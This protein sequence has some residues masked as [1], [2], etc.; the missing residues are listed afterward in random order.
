MI[1]DLLEIS[2]DCGIRSA[3]LNS[4][5]NRNAMSLQMMR[6][7]LEL[8]DEH[9]ADP[10]ARALVLGHQG[11]VFCAGIDLIERRT[12]PPDEAV[13]SE[14][15]A[16][17]LTE[18]WA[19]ETPLVCQV[20]G[21]VRGGGMG[22]LSCADFVLAGP[23]ASFAYT[24]IRVGV[25]PALVGALALLGGGGRQ[26]VP[27]LLTGETFNAETAGA[28]GLVTHVL[29]DTDTALVA[30]LNSLTQGGP[31]AQRETKRLV[32]SFSNRDVSIAIAEMTALSAQFFTSEEASEGMRAFAEK[33]PPAWTEPEQ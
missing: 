25:A 19:C 1:S 14:V 31:V 7:L 32:R 29:A 24:E 26:L 30:L 3:K 28:I 23:Q 6:D 22:L 33:R 13:H 17:L 12:L 16:E 21:P 10:G 9:K 5:S 4:E 18:L 15:L 20:D 27:W 8:L 2:V 11:P